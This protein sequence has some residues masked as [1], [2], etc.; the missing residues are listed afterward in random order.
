MSEYDEADTGEPKRDLR[1]HLRSKPGM[2]TAYEGHVD[3]H[4]TMDDAFRAAVAKLARTSFPDRPSMSSWV[5]E[6]VE[7]R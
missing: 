4:A 3:V 2:W 6:S 1:V 5:L 7:P